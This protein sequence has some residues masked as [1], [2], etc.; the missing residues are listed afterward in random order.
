MV[1]RELLNYR[2]SKDYEALY[3]LAGNQSVVCV[4]DYDRDYRDVCSTRRETGRD[5]ISVNARGTGYI[6]A[7]NLEEFCAQCE[8]LN[9]QWIP[10]NG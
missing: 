4:V 8:H 2:F 10:P 1:I 3:E 5:S 6:W 9:L 7:E